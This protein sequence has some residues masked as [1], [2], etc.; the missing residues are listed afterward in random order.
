MIGNH[1]SYTGKNLLKCFQIFLLATSRQPLL[2]TDIQ[3][4]TAYAVTVGGMVPFAVRC[5][6]VW[7]VLKYFGWAEAFTESAQS[8]VTEG[9]YFNL[10]WG[11][12]L[13]W[14]HW[15]IRLYLW[16][17][18]TIW[19]S[20]WRVKNRLFWWSS[21]FQEVY[22]EFLLYWSSIFSYLYPL[23]HNHLCSCR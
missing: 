23:N 20:T 11:D 10:P 5:L 18:G 19:Q 15:A 12:V 8:L 13:Q 21:V 14:K 3:G 9:S 6:C 7:R 16:D 22:N 2:G 1:P 17:R 4:G